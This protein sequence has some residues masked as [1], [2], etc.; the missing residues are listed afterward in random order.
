MEGIYQA[1]SVFDFNQLKLISPTTMAGGNYFI[2]FRI[3]EK[4]L[5]LQPP[6]CILKNGIQKSG[7]KL[8]SDLIFTHEN[9]EFIQWMENLEIHCRKQI[10]DNR[11]KWFETELDETDIENFF[12]SPLKIYKSGKNYSARTNIPTLL[13]NCNLKIYNENEEEIGIES[14]KENMNVVS[15]LEFQ[16]IKCSPRNFQI[17]IEIKQM[18]VLDSTSMFEKCVFNNQNKKPQNG[19]P[20]NAYKDDLVLSTNT[21][22]KEPSLEEQ[23]AT[24]TGPAPIKLHIDE[25]IKNQ[26]ETESET[27][28][29]T[30][31]VTNELEESTYTSSL[32]E[33]PKSRQNELEEID[34]NLDELPQES[35]IQLKQRDNVYYDMYKEAKRKAKM[36]RDLAISSYLEAQNIKQ[37]YMLDD[38]EDSDSDLDDDEIGNINIF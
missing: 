4:P 31:D 28:K 24:R 20:G 35:S 11:E 19:N 36:A 1:T 27:K 8:F 6:Q 9:E 5:Y 33:L 37:T 22:E 32:E 17:D 21:I 23:M 10:F 29:L 13:G 38:I 30:L 26:S 18:M 7:K 3:Q 25:P 15:V 14:L 2:K 34:F 16:G 12:T